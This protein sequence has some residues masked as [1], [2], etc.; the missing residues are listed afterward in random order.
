MAKLYTNAE[1][2]TME[3]VDLKAQRAEFDAKL[4]QLEQQIASLNITEPLLNLIK[5][6][7]ISVEK[8]YSIGADGQMVEIAEGYEGLAVGIT[9]MP[10]IFIGNKTNIIGVFGTNGVGKTYKL[11]GGF[12]AINS[13]ADLQVSSYGNFVNG[14]LIGFGT[15]SVDAGAIEVV[16]T[17]EQTEEGVVGYCNVEVVNKANGETTINQCGIMEQSTMQTG[18]IIMSAGENMV[19]QTGVFD[20]TNNQLKDGKL[21]IKEN[22]NWKVVAEVKDGQPVESVA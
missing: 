13:V 3:A 7:D 8:Y 17:G 5:G 21:Y 11:E 22:G 15:T 9:F 1:L 14:L 16:A 20:A 2:D 12:E 10:E 19:F 18:T 6:L 4:A